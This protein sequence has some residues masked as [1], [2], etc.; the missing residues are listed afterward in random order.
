MEIYNIIKGEEF[1]TDSCQ[2]ILRYMA[3][4]FSQAEFLNKKVYLLSGNL[5]SPY[6]VCEIFEAFVVKSLCD[7]ENFV[8]KVLSS[9]LSHDTSKLSE[10]LALKLPKQITSDES[11]AYLNGLSYFDLKSGSNLKTISRKILTTNTNAFQNIPN[12]TFKK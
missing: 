3:R 5:F 9:S 12:E 1:N 11:L 7:W 10:L 4:I 2:S 6:E 8:E